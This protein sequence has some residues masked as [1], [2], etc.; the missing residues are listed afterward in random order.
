M[1]FEYLTDNFNKT[2]VIYFVSDYLFENYDVRYDDTDSLNEIYGEHA[3]DLAI[4]LGKGGE[5]MKDFFTYDGCGFIEFKE[6]YEVIEDIKQQYE[7]ELLEAIEEEN[8]YIID[9]LRYLNITIDE[10]KKGLKEYDN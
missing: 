3:L 6:D 8:E 1:L 5:L 10:L 7:K 2:D 4:A 9:G